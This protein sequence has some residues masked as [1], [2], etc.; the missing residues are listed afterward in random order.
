VQGLALRR[1]LIAFFGEGTMKNANARW[2]RLLFIHTLIGSGFF[3]VLLGGFLIYIN[4]FSMFSPDGHMVR[5]GIERLLMNDS[6]IDWWIW[7]LVGFGVFIQV[8]IA[9]SRIHQLPWISRLFATLTTAIVS[10][11][12]CW[13][14]LIFAIA[15]FDFEYGPNLTFCLMSSFLLGLFLFP[16]YL[17]LFNGWLR[18]RLR[19]RKAASNQE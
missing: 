9:V 16:P 17:V 6:F 12:A 15:T 2:L 10:T 4:S 3:V 13:M 7:L 5:G 19:T 14:A 18:D 8:Y 1:M 11:F